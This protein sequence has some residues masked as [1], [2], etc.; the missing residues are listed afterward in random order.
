MTTQ[1]F[2]LAVLT[3]R[4]I[5]TS[6]PIIALIFLLQVTDELHKADEKLKLAEALLESKVQTIFEQ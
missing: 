3:V 1:T 5:C 4:Y 6:V 2:N